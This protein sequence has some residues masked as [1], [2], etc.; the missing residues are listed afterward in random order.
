MNITRQVAEIPTR[1]GIPMAAVV[2]RPAASTPGSAGKAILFCQ[3]GLQNKGGAGDYF[4][5]LA[6]EL[7]AAGH[8]VVRFDALGT[9][10]S[11]GE[12][13]NDV[14]LEQFFVKIQEGASAD[15]TVDALRWTREQAP[16]R[17]IFLWG[18]CGGCVT[19]L[20]ACAREPALASGLVLL[21][22]PVLY[23]RELG[24]V[25]DFD[26]RMAR[27]GYAQKLLQ[28]R[29]WLRLLRGQSEYKLVLAAAMSVVKGA[30]RR[31]DALRDRLRREPQPDHPL[32]NDKMY[33]AFRKVMRA[34]KP[35]LFLNAELDNETPEFRDAFQHKVLDCQSDYSRLCDVKF[36]EKAD[37]SLM[38]MDAR[39]L[40]RDL[41][42][43]WL[44]AR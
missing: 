31:A 10:D 3:A 2:T 1:S 30:R 22:T 21:A 39:R 41:M 9:G 38:F 17:D 25:R 19:A 14:A 42:L 23:S 28:P 11:P 16:G 5:W 12:I 13:A 7:A 24:A 18:Q 43:A 4:R 27:K 6:D 36:I 44:A 26:A 32:F 40:S 35:I 37:H 15:D 29:A 20:M 8:V 33:E 34:S